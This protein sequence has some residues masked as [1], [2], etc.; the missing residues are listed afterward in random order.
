MNG[1]QERIPWKPS[2][3]DCETV[4]CQASQCGIRKRRRLRA[5][6][7]AGLRHFLD[8]FRY[9][10]QL[11]SLA[12]HGVQV[13]AHNTL[14]AS[15]YGL[16]D[17]KTLN[18]RPNYWAALLWRQLMGTTVLD[19]GT[20]PAENLLLYAQ[21]MR[22]KPGGVVLLAINADRTTPQSIQV[23]KAGDRYTLTAKD[24]MSSE[25]QLNGVTLTVG[26]DNAIPKMV[27]IANKSEATTFAPASVTFLTFPKADNQSCR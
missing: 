20:S 16:I 19:A 18:P 3:P 10:N 7:I 17:E 15:N 23:P 4:S 25:V 5:A 24:L 14:A 1:F 21:C 11:G 8:S 12:K 22:G 13:V 9:L 6:A 27:G 2:I 26:R